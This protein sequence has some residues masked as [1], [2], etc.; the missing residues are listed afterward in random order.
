MDGILVSF[1]EGL[2]SGT[3]LVLGCKTQNTSKFLHIPN[4]PPFLLT[5]K[6][7]VASAPTWICIQIL[8]M[9][10]GNGHQ[11]RRDLNFFQASLQAIFL[12]RWIRQ[13]TFFGANSWEGM[14]QGSWKITKTNITAFFRGYS[15]NIPQKYRV[16]NIIYVYVPWSKVAILGMVIPPSIGIL[17]MGI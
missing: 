17:I 4:Q 10:R 16:Y 3:I 13:M 5:K 11:C 6:I 1:W 7:P 15:R 12:R 9:C 8:H 14:L 2:F